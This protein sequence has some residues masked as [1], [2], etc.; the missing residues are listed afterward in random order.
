MHGV[1]D[2]R[3]LPGTRLRHRPGIHPERGSQR[4]PEPLS[5][6]MLARLEPEPPARIRFASLRQ[7]RE[8]RRLAQRMGELFKAIAF[9]RGI[10]G[11]I[12]AF[13]RG[14][15]SHTLWGEEAEPTPPDSLQ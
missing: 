10:D 3:R 14:D 2:L 5:L 9:S 13:S 6:R 15:R 7:L 11:V 4:H 12:D 1:L 8:P